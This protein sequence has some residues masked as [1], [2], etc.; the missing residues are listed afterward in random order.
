MTG[1]GVSTVSTIVLDVSQAI[2]TNM[3]SQCITHHFPQ[4][5]DQFKEEM[6]DFEQLWQFQ[7]CWGAIDGCHIPI[8]F[9]K[10]GAESGKEYYNL[11]IFYP[12]LL[13][14]IVNAKYRWGSSG[15]AG[16]S[17]D[18]SIFQSTHLWDE[19][20]QGNVIPN[21]SAEVDGVRVSP[22]VV[23]ESAFPLATWLMRPYTNATLSSEQR[24]LNYHLSRARMVTEGGYRQFKG[25]WRIVLRK[26]ESD[27]ENFK[28]WTLACMVL[29][30]I[31]LDLGDALPS[32]L[33]LSINPGSGERRDR[34]TINP[35]LHMY[36]SPPELDT[37]HQAKLIRSKLTKKCWD[38][39]QGHGVHWANIHNTPVFW[40]GNRNNIVV[41]IQ[42]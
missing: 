4:D 5:S 34:A 6:L 40:T 29:G 16:T 27:P 2:I 33:D 18:S 41:F 7:Y 9:P 24:Y 26:C 21:I 10:G 30:N 11:K 20:Q 28:M 25:Q 37:N 36:L 19:I 39:K 8:K 1:F 31:C 22:F 14:A 38:E 12:V 23:G 42:W 35:L 17:H 13:M 15:F 32:K 3:W